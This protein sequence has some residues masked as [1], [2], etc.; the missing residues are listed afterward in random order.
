MVAEVLHV[1]SELAEEG[2]TMLVVTHE[3]SFARA[4]ADRV[5]FMDDGAIVEEGEP[6]AFFTRP[7]TERARAFLEQILPFE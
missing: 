3:L 7:A 5:V 2:M 1:V 4:V 6:E